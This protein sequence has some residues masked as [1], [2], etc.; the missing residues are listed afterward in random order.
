M[1]MTINAMTQAE[2][3][4]AS[5]KHPASSCWTTLRAWPVKGRI[6]HARISQTVKNWHIQVAKS[7]EK[8]ASLPIP[9]SNRV[10]TD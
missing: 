7:A 10:V 2:A 9:L 1:E 4:A 3:T 6:N 8:L 5:S